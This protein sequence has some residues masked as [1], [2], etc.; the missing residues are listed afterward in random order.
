MLAFG[1]LQLDNTCIEG[2]GLAVCSEELFESLRPPE[3]PAYK[4]HPSSS[5]VL[6]TK[7]TDR[8]NGLWIQRSELLQHPLL[9]DGSTRGAGGHGTLAPIT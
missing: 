3:L 9:R 6:T 8:H 2:V 1:R 4:H 7:I 5:V